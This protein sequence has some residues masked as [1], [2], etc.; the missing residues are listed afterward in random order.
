M[1]S[2]NAVIILHLKGKGADSFL[3]SFIFKTY[4]NVDGLPPAPIKHTWCHADIGR[5]GTV[6]FHP[7]F[8]FSG[9][10]SHVEFRSDPERKLKVKGEGGSRVNQERAEAFQCQLRVIEG[11]SDV[12]LTERLPLLPELLHELGVGEAEGEERV[13]VHREHR[14]ARLATGLQL[15]PRPPPLEPSLRRARIC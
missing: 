2:V 1:S 10:R 8:S 14:R 13:H 12:V 4:I 7:F 11:I 5:L 3:S 15:G 6:T 9:S